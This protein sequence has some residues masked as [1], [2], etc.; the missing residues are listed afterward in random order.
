MQKGCNNSHKLRYHGRL[1]CSQ[2][3]IF[4]EIVDVAC[5]SLS[6]MG[7]HLGLLTS[8]NWGEYKIPVGRGG[9]GHSRRKK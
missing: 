5:R 9:G 7:C 1:D 3:P 2:S 4:R 6:L 8:R